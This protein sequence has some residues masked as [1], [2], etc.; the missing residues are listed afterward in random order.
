MKLAEFFIHE[1][2]EKRHS[3]HCVCHGRNW[4]WQPVHGMTGLNS[5][6]PISGNKKITCPYGD[7]RV[8]DFHSA[9]SGG[10]EEDW[11]L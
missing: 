6:T 8:N 2:E 7:L 11:D 10:G 3:L 9:A 5:S 1:A 4:I